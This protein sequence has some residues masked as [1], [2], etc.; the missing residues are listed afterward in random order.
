MIRAKQ[1][2]LS[3]LP[4]EKE[5]EIK[6]ESFLTENSMYPSGIGVTSLESANI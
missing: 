3:L 1:T 2:A 5:V 6:I 4:S